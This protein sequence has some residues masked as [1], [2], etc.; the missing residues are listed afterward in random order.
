[1]LIL[2]TEAKSFKQYHIISNILLLQKQIKQYSLS[3]I[4]CKQ[5]IAYLIKLSN[6]LKQYPNTS[7]ILL[8]ENQAI[9]SSCVQ[10]DMWPHGLDPCIGSW[11]SWLEDYDLNVKLLTQDCKAGQIHA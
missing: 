1:M 10:H 8:P 5:Y 9:Y 3:N 7:N 2:S 4:T 6:V 11:D